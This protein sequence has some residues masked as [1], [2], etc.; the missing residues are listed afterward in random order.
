MDVN[1]DHRTGGS[2]FSISR[3]P[4]REK[5]DCAMGLG[6]VGDDASR[7]VGAHP[8]EPGPV[9]LVMIDEH[10]DGGIRG[11]VLQALEI[12]GALGFGVDRE[13]QLVAIERE[14]DRHDVRS[15]IV[16]YGRKACDP[17]VGN[18]APGLG[19]FHAVKCG[20]HWDYL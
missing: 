5:L 15:P 2:G 3:I 11:D 6:V 17:G 8:P 1:R 20:P 16:A 10:R 9:L 4:P 14:D 7:A 12:R 13:V 18:A 19:G